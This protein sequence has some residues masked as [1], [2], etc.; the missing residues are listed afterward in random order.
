[1]DTLH[2]TFFKTMNGLNA[3]RRK[4]VSD[5][6][7]FS[8]VKNEK[9]QYRRHFNVSFSSRFPHYEGACLS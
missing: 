7:N 9:T 6:A 2:P 5:L 8:T 3:N 1:M 4:L